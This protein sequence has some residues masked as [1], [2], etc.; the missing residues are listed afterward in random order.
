MGIC[1]FAVTELRRVEVLVLI[2][3]IVGSFIG[4]LPK[5][6]HTA[7][8][9]L[10][11]DANTEPDLAGYRIYH[12]TGSGVYPNVSDVGNTTTATI[13]NLTAGQ[14]YYFAVTAY[15]TEGLESGYSNQV[16][17]LPPVTGTTYSITS[18]AG[19][20]GS[21]SPSGTVAL[22]KGTSKTFAIAAN[23]GYRIADVK[24]DGSSVGAVGS[25][26]FSN[27]TANHTISASFSANSYTIS[28][29]AGANGSISP[30]GSVSV[31]QG[32]SQSF[33]VT[34]G[35][36]CR[37]ADVKVDGSS[38]G[39]MG[40]YTFS[41]VTANHTITASFSANSYTI[42]ASAGANGSISPSGSV[43]VAQGGSQSFTVTPSSGCGIADVK[44]DGSSVG[45]VS[46][47]TFSNVTANH[48]ITASF[49]ASSY[50]ISAS[51][52]SNGSIS[53][54]GSVSV[55]SGGSQS[56]TVTP[57]SG[58]RIAD[59]KVD[60]SSVGAVGSYTFSNVTSN[61]SISAS[62]EQDDSNQDGLVM[63]TGTVVVD[64][65]WQRVEFQETYSN[66]VVIA[67]AASLEDSDP[68]VVRVRNV[69]ESGFEIRIQEWDYLDNIH[70]EETVGYIVLEAGHH[71]LSDGTAVEAGWFETNQVNSFGSVSFENTFQTT[72]IVVTTISSFNE[73]DVVAGRIRDINSN[74]FK[75]C[76]QEQEANSQSHAKEIIN[77]VAWEPSCGVLHNVAFEV[78]KT[79]N[80]ITD[81][82]KMIRFCQ[83]YTDFPVF[84]ADMQTSNGMD[85]ADVR[86][87]NLQTNSVEI[88]IDEEK[89][90]D[91]ET[92]HT[93]E[94]VGYIIFDEQ[95]SDP[96]DEVV[97][98]ADFNIGQ[99]GFTYVHDVFGDAS[100]PGYDTAAWSASGGV[101]GGALR[102]TLGGIDNASVLH[103][104][105]GWQQAFTL[106]DAA[107]VTLSFSYKLTQTSNYE[108]D[109]LSQ[110]LV[111]IDEVLHGQGS[112]DYVAQIA[113]DGN[114]GSP[115]STGWQYVQLN[116]GLIPAGTHTF[117]IGGY[118]NKK[119][120]NDESSEILIDD[121]QVMTTRN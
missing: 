81:Q 74:G 6:A 37:I 105:G 97:L 72:P 59:V 48:T 52:G 82:F 16:S 65:V 98:Q 84:I 58:Y 14:T 12:G 111:S 2:T 87:R 18:A 91:A 108:S 68:A 25:Y 73:S 22:N 110:V 3:L 62:F 55:A 95:S 21:I 88:R 67:N 11:W 61:R 38:V 112:S 100:A 51:A 101:T 46:S 39:A 57:S 1:R 45:A 99:N 7:D 4:L 102:V 83:S 120:Y 79:T 30:S 32:G 118:N 96:V 40:S 13:S 64:H 9:T 42:T 36:G 60:G 15:D 10:T 23:S 94:V 5:V 17:Y 119:T 19:A 106:S 80:S 24:V 104:S 8:V 121:V 89:S 76:M 31:A 116:L 49:S 56:F 27:V 75:Y 35:S 77:F 63:E 93:S 29:S 20:N 78:G 86:W 114:G 28:A 103:M 69:D 85:T 66:P 47:Y 92:R 115:I 117:I 71:I 34:P 50:T 41:N 90:A 44:V 109:E 113:G 54:S 26:T 33:T 70:A 107:E 53:P 43:T